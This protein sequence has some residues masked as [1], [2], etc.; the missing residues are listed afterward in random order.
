MAERPHV[1]RRPCFAMFASFNDFI[2]LGANQCS[3]LESGDGHAVSE[4][5]KKIAP[6]IASH[7]ASTKKERLNITLGS[8]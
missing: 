3:E 6:R 8:D 4:S 7:A 2:L 5:C 1:P